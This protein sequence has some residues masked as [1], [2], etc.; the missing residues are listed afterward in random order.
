MPS[1]FP[2]ERDGQQ[3]FYPNQPLPPP[4]PPQQRFDDYYG[5]ENN[6]IP[7]QY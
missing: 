7:C 5:N 6:R 1:S 4:L 2:R 3:Q